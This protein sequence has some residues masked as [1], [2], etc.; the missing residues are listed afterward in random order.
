MSIYEHFRAEEHAFI[1]QVLEWR[2]QVLSQYALKLTDF[3]DPREQH[4][5][6]TVI[7]HDEEVRLA[8]F[9]GSEQAERKRA[10]LYPPYFEPSEDDFECTLFEINY[11]QKFIT[12]EHP[13]V[14][15]S[16][17]S[18]GLKRSKFGDIPTD[19]ENFQLVVAAEIADYVRMNLTS[20]G[21]ATIELIERPFSQ[22]INQVDEWKEG[23]G[24]VSSMRLDAVLAEIH[25]MSRQKVLSLIQ[26]GMAKVNFKVVER[27][28]YGCEEGDLFS[29]RGHGRSKLI[30]IGGKTKKNKWRITYGMKNK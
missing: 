13:K 22:V 23:S 24:T 12:I 17:M 26:N 7:G 4:I 30:E 3:L 16:V 25:S 21:K 20:V 28:D 14:L 10:I 5:M 6:K 1:D 27:P 15:G 8:F 19:G 18:L 9:G 11:P 2:E 29:L